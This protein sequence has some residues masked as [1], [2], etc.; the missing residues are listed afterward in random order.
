[1]RARRRRSFAAV[2][3]RMRID[4]PEQEAALLAPRAA[5]RILDLLL[6]LPGGSQ[7]AA[8]LPDCFSPPPEEPAT[9]EGA[10]GSGGGGGV[11]EGPDADQLW[12]TPLQLLNEI[13]A[14]TRGAA[15][16]PATMDRS[17]GAPA[18][19]R[20][21]GGAHHGLSGEAYA[22]ALRQLREE[23]ATRW[24]DSLPGAGPRASDSG[25][26]P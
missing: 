22:S 12:C 21:I 10:S 20:A 26:E 15:A 3:G 5:A 24:L 16:A 23:V 1:M 4:S 25:S 17:E 19:A 11:V 13:D 8:L 9:A 2:A 6:S 18:S 7:R 14:R